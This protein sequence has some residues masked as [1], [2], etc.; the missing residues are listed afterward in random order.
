V[1]QDIRAI[2]GRI[3]LVHCNNSRDEAGSGRDRHAP[4]VGGE[5]DTAVLIEI[6]RTAGAPVILETPGGSAERAAEIAMLRSS[7]G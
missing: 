3:D 5:I 2:T 7:L 4:L 6:V 1:V